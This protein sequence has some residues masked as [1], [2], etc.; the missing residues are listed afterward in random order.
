MSGTLWKDIGF[1]LGLALLAAVVYNLT[2]GNMPWIREPKV[3][4]VVPDSLLFQSNTTTTPADTILT[5]TYEQVLKLLQDPQV[6]FVDARPPEE[7]EAGHIDNAVNIYALEFEDHIPQILEW[8]PDQLIIVYCGG[9]T[10]E[11]S[12]DL[13]QDLKNFGFTRVFVYSGGWQEWSQKQ[14]E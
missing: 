5:V 10:C 12:H 9:G 6:L 8:D 7:Y 11:L 1:L 4:P 14:H 13:A 2:L 3:E